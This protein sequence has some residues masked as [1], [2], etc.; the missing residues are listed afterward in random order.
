MRRWLVIAAV[1]TTAAWLGAAPADSQAPKKGG[2]LKIGLIGEPP[3][4]TAMP[5]RR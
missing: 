2:I 4:S 1:L 5:P 3:C